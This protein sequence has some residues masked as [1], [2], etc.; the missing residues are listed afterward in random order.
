MDLENTFSQEIGNR[1]TL[2][3][4]WQ[5]QHIVS[6]SGFSKQNLFFVDQLNQRA[7]LAIHKNLHVEEELLDISSIW[8][9]I[10]KSCATC[11]KL[12]VEFNSL[13]EIPLGVLLLC[14]CQGKCIYNGVVKQ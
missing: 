3:T 2:L 9:D 11:G 13:R 1:K 12:A 6:F 4:P 14:I 5:D 8:D 10:L 7:R